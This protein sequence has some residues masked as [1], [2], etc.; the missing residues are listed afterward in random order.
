MGGCEVV[1][2]LGD[3]LPKLVCGARGGF[4]Q[5]FYGM[6]DP[7]LLSSIAVVVLGGTLIT[8]RRGHY[9]GILGGAIL[10]TALGIML[11]GTVLPE[12]VRNIIT[13]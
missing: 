11:S 6:G 10:F 8:G 9:L 13:A 3:D 4:S 2:G 12:A 1:Y 5:T 7:Y